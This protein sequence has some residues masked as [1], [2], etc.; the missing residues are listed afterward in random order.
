MSNL[1]VLRMS[2]RTLRILLWPFLARSVQVHDK[3]SH[4]SCLTPGG[5]PPWI[6]WSLMM[7][8]AQLYIA[9]SLQNPPQ[10]LKSVQIECNTCPLKD[11][12]LGRMNIFIVML[13]KMPNNAGNEGRVASSVSSCCFPSHSSVWIHDSIDKAQLPHTFSTHSSLYKSST[14]SERHCG[15]RTS[16][17]TPPLATPEHFGCFCIRNVWLGLLR[18][19]YGLPE[20]S[21][22]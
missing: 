4:L 12:H 11:F 2:S 16:H 17:C 20:V 1:L 19:D 9:F 22:L 6:L 7:S 5:W 3:C 10:L 21:I 8:F 15:P 14:T 13:E 18:P